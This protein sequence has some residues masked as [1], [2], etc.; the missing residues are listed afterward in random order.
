MIRAVVVIIAVTLLAN[1]LKLEPAH[2]LIP[3]GLIGL[4]LAVKWRLSTSRI[5]GAR[6]ETHRF[7]PGQPLDTIKHELG[8]KR[9]ILREGGRVDRFVVNPDGSGY[10]R[11]YL[12]KR[13]GVVGRVASSAAG[14]VAE[15]SWVGAKYDLQDIEKALAELPPEEREAARRQGIARARSTMFWNSVDGEAKRIYRKGWDGS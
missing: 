1:K 13:A 14:S 4:V 2:L 10:V 12:P 5:A 8:H 9:Q 15:G 7:G 11:G 6:V 3:V